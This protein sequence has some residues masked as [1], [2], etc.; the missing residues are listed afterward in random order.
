MTGRL[1]PRDVTR[2]A[3]EAVAATDDPQQLVDGLRRALEEQE[4][5]K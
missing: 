2:A 5:K 3:V 4:P 1:D